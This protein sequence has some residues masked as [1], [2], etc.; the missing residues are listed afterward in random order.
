MPHEAL[1]VDDDAEVR[2]A[3]AEILDSLGHRY[4]LPGQK[5]KR[6]S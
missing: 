2:E 6:P 1:V 3:V 5:R 4:D